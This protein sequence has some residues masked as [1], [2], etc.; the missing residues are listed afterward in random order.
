MTIERS[1]DGR[2]IEM[3]CDSCPAAFP[4][5][6]DAGDFEI[7]LAD[8]RV[9]GWQ[10]IRMGLRWRHRCPSCAEAARQEGRLI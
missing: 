9:A 1:E 10:A 7:L 3:V 8:A 6:H 2:Q 4:A 5:V